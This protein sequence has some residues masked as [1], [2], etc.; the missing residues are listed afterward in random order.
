MTL[1]AMLLA[2]G[3]PAWIWPFVVLIRNPDREGWGMHGLLAL[4]VSGGLLVSGGVIQLL[5]TLAA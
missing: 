3:L 4:M 5:V 1:A 2:V